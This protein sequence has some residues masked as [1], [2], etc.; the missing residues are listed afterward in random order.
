MTRMLIRLGHAETPP[1]PSGWLHA[2]T[3]HLCYGLYGKPTWWVADSDQHLGPDASREDGEQA[4]AD[5][6]TNPI[7]TAESIESGPMVRDI[8]RS[9]PKQRQ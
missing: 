5:L 6:A 8:E 1:Q 4:T 3:A 9:A 2:D 7:P